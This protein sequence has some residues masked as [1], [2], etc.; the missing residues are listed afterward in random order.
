[1]CRK[2]PADVVSSAKSIASKLG[3][4]AAKIESAALLAWYKGADEEAVLLIT[5]SASVTGSDGLPLVNAGAILDMYGLPEKAIPILRTVVANDPKSAIAHNNLGQAYTSIGMLDSAMYYFGKCLGLSSQHPE[6][7]NTAGHIELKRGNKSKAQTYFE[8]SLRGGYTHSAYV[9]LKT[10]L[11]EKTR[12]AHL[13]K[14]K[15]KFPEYFNQFKYKLPRQCEN[16]NDAATVQLEFDNYK[17]MLSGVMR[18]A[19]LAGKEAEKAMGKNWAVEMNQRTMDA[20]M[21]GESYLRPFQTLGSIIDAEATVGYVAD[22]NDLMKFNEEN[23]AEY[24]KLEEDYKKAYEQMMQSGGG[25]ARENA[26]KNKYLEQFALLN[27][28]WQSRNMLIE[29]KYI[30]DYLYWCY[31]AA[32][33]INDYKHRFYSYMYRYLYRLHTSHR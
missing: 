22:M 32:A 1:M 16:V 14:P 17:K 21:K 24:K 6:A 10:I 11:K 8:N 29:N 2:F 4:N 13:I 28:E 9:G 19:D 20:V 27:S 5:K 26:L 31:F 12:I 33:D 23:R 3:N 25:C 15:V 18:Q 30:D 7:N